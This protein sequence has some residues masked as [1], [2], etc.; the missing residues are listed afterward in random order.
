MKVVINA[1]F[2][3]FSLS[4]AAYEWMIAHGVPAR[5]Y[6]ERER[7]PETKLYLSSDE[8]DGEVIFDRDM[9]DNE[10]AVSVR[11]RTLAGRYWDTWT[12]GNRSHPMLLGAIAALGE[13][14]DGRYAKLAV[15]EIPDDIQ[16]TIEE[17]DGSEHVAEQHRTWG[18]NI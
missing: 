13:Q 2:G 9:S 12:D 5:M 18:E 7:D 15:V 17:Y 4:D 8:N 10:S 16:Y 14:A 11:M 3:G 1:C 6:I